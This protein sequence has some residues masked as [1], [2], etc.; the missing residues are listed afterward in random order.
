MISFKV[1]T[2][3]T[4]PE[5]SKNTLNQTKKALGFI[6]NLF[7][8][9]AEAPAA[10]NGYA[11]LSEQFDKTSLSPAERQ[12]VLLATS[13]ENECHYCMAVHSTLA[14]MVSV[15]AD[16]IRALREGRPIQDARLEGLRQFVR[17]LVQKRGW[18]SGEDVQAFLNAGYRQPQI[19]EVLVGVTLKTLSNYTNHIAQTP[20][21]PAFEPAKWNHPA[22]AHSMAPVM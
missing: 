21:D 18:V 8:T 2:P 9:F 13:F 15:P 10:L 7:G 1:H 17:K 11:A 5:G 14:K 19:L 4:A 12:V 6:P 20:L 22:P 3:E 16:T